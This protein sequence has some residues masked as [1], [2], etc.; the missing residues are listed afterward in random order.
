MQSCLSQLKTGSLRQQR[1]YSCLT[2]LEVLDLLLEFNATLVSTICLDI[3][4]PES[5]LDIICE[6][7]DGCLFIRTLEER[8]GDRKQFS[9]KRW[10]DSSTIVCK[11]ISH[12][13]TL[14]IFGQPIPVQQQ[15]AYLHFRQTERLLRLGGEKTRDAI[16]GLKISGMKTEPAIAHLLQ[17]AGDPYEAVISLNEFD[18]QQLL[19]RLVSRGLV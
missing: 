13:F 16:R 17:L 18:D 9:I 12:G 6:A 7:F 11:F 3:H 19:N 10:K 15:V 5:D 8:F 14:E 1:A 4:T 2:E